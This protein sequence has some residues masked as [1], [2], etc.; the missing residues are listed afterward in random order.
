MEAGDFTDWTKIPFLPINIK[1]TTFYV[2]FDCSSGEWKKQGIIESSESPEI[3]QI[4]EE[5][6]NIRIKNDILLDMLTVK[7][8]D[9]IEAQKLKK[10]LEDLV[11]RSDT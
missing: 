7:D 2:D 4:N 11:A 10:E 9:L 1:F 6:E 3:R 5:I 8:L